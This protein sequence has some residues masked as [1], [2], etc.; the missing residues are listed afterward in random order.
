MK[1]VNTTL[2]KD[3]IISILAAIGVALL[4]IVFLYNKASFY[5]VIPESQEYTMPEKML[6]EINKTYTEDNTQIVTT[7][8][9][10]AADL[11][12]YEKTKEYNKGKKDPFALESDTAEGG[13]L[14]DSSKT[15]EGN[16]SG[17][18]GFYP[19]DGTK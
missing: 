5:K 19:D 12:K 7:Y 15:S 18:S 9:I 16:S 10:D 11:K 4:V 6:E 14:G 3:V 2:I 1:K 17:N 8:Y 13:E